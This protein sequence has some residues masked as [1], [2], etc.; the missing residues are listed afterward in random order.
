M[1]RKYG[2]E[3]SVVGGWGAGDRDG[4]KEV[5]DGRYSGS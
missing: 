3:G 4:I 1:K 2:R 5:E